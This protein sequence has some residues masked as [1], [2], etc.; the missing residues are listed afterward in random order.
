[1]HGKTL[2][3]MKTA[4]IMK[5]KNPETMLVLYNGPPY[6]ILHHHDIQ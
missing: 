1:M 4:L 3:M 6:T 2:V 5:G